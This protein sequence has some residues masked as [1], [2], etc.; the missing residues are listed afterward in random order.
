MANEIPSSA[1]KF[2]TAES[3]GT[4]VTSGTSAGATVY[5]RLIG[6]F[7]EALTGSNIGVTFPYYGRVSLSG[8]KNF[9]CGA[10]VEPFTLN[11]PTFGNIEDVA[12]TSAEPYIDFSGGSSDWGNG[13]ATI[14]ETSGTVLIGFYLNIASV[15]I[16]VTDLIGTLTYIKIN[17]QDATSG[18]VF[19]IPNDIGRVKRYPIEI[20]MNILANDTISERSVANISISTGSG[21]TYITIDQAAGASNLSL[22]VNSANVSSST[23]LSSTAVTITANDN[24]TV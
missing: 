7:T 15:T 2:F 18:S 17:G 14:A 12:N 4:E 22:S 23:G 6:P 21:N 11:L 5:P 8:T 1:I 16:T 20:A 13:N 10:D 9:V 19:N 3:G 24:W